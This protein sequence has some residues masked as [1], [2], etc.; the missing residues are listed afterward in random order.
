VNQRHAPPRSYRP[1]SKTNAAALAFTAIFAVS[2]VLYAAID[3]KR[4]HELVVWSSNEKSALLISIA[5]AYKPP[6]VER[7]CVD[8]VVERVPSGDAELALRRGEPINGK[9]PHVWSPAANTWALLLS[10]HRKELG[11]REI[12]P[13]ALRSL[14]KSPLVIAMPQKLYNTLRECRAEIGWTYILGLARDPRLCPLYSA[15]W[16]RFRLAKTD[17]NVSTSGLHALISTYNAGV[18]KTG[19]LTLEEIRQNEVRSFVEGVEE[20]VVHYGDSVGNFL[21]SLYAE[22]Q[23]GAALKYVSAI[24]VEE[25]QVFDYNFAPRSPCPPCPLP[26]DE[27][28]V[29]IYPEEGTLVADH[30]YLVLNADWVQSAHQKAALDFLEHLETEA[31]QQRFLKDGFRN[32]AL[33]GDPEVL[34]A[35]HFDLNEP[36]R[37]VTL[38]PSAVLAQMQASWF[39]LRKRANILLVFDVAESMNREIADPRVTKLELVKRATS[40]ALKNLNLE[41]SVGLWTFSTRPGEPY[42]DVVPLEQLSSGDAL[43][44]AVAGLEA[45]TG[46]RQLNAAV[47]ASVDRLRSNFATDRI[48][49]V[50][51]LSNGDDD[52]PRSSEFLA[53]LAYLRDQP[54]DQ[55]V[56][57]FTIAYD[58]SAKEALSQIAVASKGRSYD[59]SN[60]LDIANVLRVVISN[61]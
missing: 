37:T 8:V 56:R 19:P 18:H 1:T 53:L 55:R 27:K 43:S 61:F 54:E 48:N 60:P 45:G 24:A 29:A 34:T 28:L 22:D 50:V 2:V 11:L 44:R 52:R 23:R 7:R 42:K 10:Q 3:S 58:E 13:L 14:I 20:S 49:A 33:H 25:K 59:A 30:P 9:K 32:D 6:D 31:V 51:V 41:D 38:S 17:P 46:G 35:P 39:D 4:C 15:Q 12:V 21:E 57:V 16:G 40:D 5:A 47:R 26:P 36:K